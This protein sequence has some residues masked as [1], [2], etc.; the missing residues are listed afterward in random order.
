LTDLVAQTALV[1]VTQLVT[2]S[3]R[4]P[5]RVQGCELLRAYGA[6][7][8]GVGAE[9]PE[10]ARHPRAQALDLG[11]LV[12]AGHLR[13]IHGRR[14]APDGRQWRLPTG[15]G[16]AGF[17][18]AGLH[19][20]HDRGGSC[21]GPSARQRRRLDLLGHRPAGRQWR[22]RLAVCRVRL[23]HP[24]GLTAR[25]DG[26]RLVQQLVLVPALQPG[27]GVH[28]AVVSH[29]SAAVAPLASRRL[30]GSSHYGGHSGAQRL[31]ADHCVGG[32][33]HGS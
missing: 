14:D 19:G 13:R 22:V 26:G 28:A 29:W 1:V 15:T 25:G 8:G 10:E 17:P 30:P 12:H 23:H 24:R 18:G 20:V 33:D 27:I 3:G 4:Y 6:D 7:F 16:P 21:C 32:A 31:G 11:S 5:H 9:A 2:M